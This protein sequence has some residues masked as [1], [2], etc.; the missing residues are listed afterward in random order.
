[1]IDRRQVL[2]ATGLLL[3]D[4]SACGGPALDQLAAGPLAQVIEIRSGDSLV[5]QGGQIVRLA[6]TAAPFG[7]QLYAAEARE[8]LAELALGQTVQLLFG[9]ARQD[10]YGRTLAHVRRQK[11]RLWL[12]KAMLDQGA[13]RVRTY[14]D[15][16]ALART[17]LDAEAVA[18]KGKKGLWTLLAYRVRLP[19]EGAVDPF[20]FQIVEG[21]VS[22]AS[23]QGVSLEN[24]VQADIAPQARAAF[25]NAGLTA[26]ALKGKLVRLRGQC[27]PGRQQALLALDHPEQLELLRES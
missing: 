2:A 15:N 8:A 4:L 14:A 12:Q 17:L 10:P 19:K 24:W 21:R 3:P 7:D 20:G 13:A 27:S 11:D 25:A 23:G 1:M 9:G 22:A 18:R 16:R 26:D 5:L 6:A